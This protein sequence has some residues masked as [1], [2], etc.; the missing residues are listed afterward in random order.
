MPLQYPVLYKTQDVK[1]DQIVSN[2]VATAIADAEQL[3]DPEK[4]DG[5]FP[6]KGFG[7]KKLDI[8]DIAK[9]SAATA[10]MKYSNSWVITITT[11]R[12]WQNVISA[13]LTD[14]LYVVITG[15][16]NLDANPDMTHMQ[17]IADGVEYPV[18]NIE[19]S[20]GWDVATAYFAHPVIVRPEKKILIYVR[21]ETAGDKRFGLL[22]YTVAK[23]SYLLNR[24]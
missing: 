17:I 7:I 21:A 10:G 9:N 18:M 6:V 24:V 20:Y 11:A 3:W 12:T 19:E 4:F 15:F 16:F 5:V 22:G 13:T 2:A 8:L 14:N 23:R 1:G